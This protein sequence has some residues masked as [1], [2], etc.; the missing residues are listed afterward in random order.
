L[1]NDEGAREVH[2]QHLAEIIDAVLEQ[3][4]E[5]HDAGVVHEDVRNFSEG[6][7]HRLDCS[8]IGDVRTEG[9]G[10]RKRLRVRTCSI[11]I[12]VD[13]GNAITVRGES[14]CDRGAE[15]TCCTGDQC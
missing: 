3:R 5:P 9:R 12:P 10:T 8:S 2:I 13:D 14:A 7:E 1:R 4:T 15:P 6:I 11:A